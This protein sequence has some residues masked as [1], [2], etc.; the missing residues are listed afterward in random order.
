MGRAGADSQN[1]M[2]VVKGVGEGAHGQLRGGFRPGD[3]PQRS[4]LSRLIRKLGLEDRVDLVGFV[5]HREV[6]RLLRESDLFIMPSV[7]TPSGDRDGIPTVILEALAQE[8]P[9]VA[10]EVSGIPEVIRPAVTGWLVPPAD[11]EALA[12]AVAEACSNPPEARRRA[13]AGRDLVAREF[14]SVKNY[15]R[16]KAL[17]EQ[18]IG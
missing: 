2:S 18:L 7:I 13:L 5:P 12:R 6:P 15:S 14:D 17:F 8:V 16:L 9:V 4:Q 10:T 11:P 3:G 1:G